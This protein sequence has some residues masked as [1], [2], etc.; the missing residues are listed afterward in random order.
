MRIP[1]Q[2][3]GKMNISWARARNLLRWSKDAYVPGYSIADGSE[4]VAFEVK[5]NDKLL[6]FSNFFRFEVPQSIAVN[7][8]KVYA[9]Q[10]D[11]KRIEV[12]KK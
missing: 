6:F 10:A 3:S 8:I 1:V 7:D 4:A 12:T 11:G 2:P 5:R 9:V